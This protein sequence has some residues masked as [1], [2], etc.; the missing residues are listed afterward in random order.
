MHEAL[1]V[2]TPQPPSELA[3]D[4]AVRMVLRLAASLKAD[5]DDVGLVCE[6]LGLSLEGTLKRDGAR[7]RA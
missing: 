7:R 4:R 3:N 6:M 5:V 1:S 2:I